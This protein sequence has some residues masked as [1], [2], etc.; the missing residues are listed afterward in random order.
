MFETAYAQSSNPNPFAASA[1]NIANGIRAADTV[2][3]QFTAVLGGSVIAL[4]IAVAL[5]AFLIGGVYYM[6]VNTRGSSAGAASRTDVKWFLVNAVL[7]LTVMV[8]I[9]GIVTLV[10]DLVLGDKSNVKTI[11]PAQ[12]Q[13]Q[14]S[15]GGPSPFGGAPA[16]AP[17]TSGGGLPLPPGINPSTAGGGRGGTSLG[18]GV[19]C[20]LNSQCTSGLCSSSGVCKL[21]LGSTCDNNSDC[22]T[23]Y[24]QLQGSGQ[25]GK[26]WTTA[27]LVR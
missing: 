20:Q 23:N 3:T 14:P 2:T 21:S 6:W 7:I 15:S 22:D 1:N 26:C 5:V 13:F 17:S 27:S 9:W 12:V 11:Q 10:S 16:A 25:R 19:S 24:C 4:L 8:S 18:V